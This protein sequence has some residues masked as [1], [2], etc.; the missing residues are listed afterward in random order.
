[1]IK[2]QSDTNTP[3]NAGFCVLL[4]EHFIRGKRQ[5]Q[6][7][8]GARD[9]VR[10]TLNRHQRTSGGDGSIVTLDGGDVVVHYICLV[11]SDSL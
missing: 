8:P 5:H 2:S 9:E 7:F 10:L 11:V 1:M 4:Y 6:W 3:L